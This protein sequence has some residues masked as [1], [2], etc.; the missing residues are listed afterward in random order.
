M[1]CDHELANEWARC[2]GKNASYIAILFI[3]L[4]SLSLLLLLHLGISR[5]I[6]IHVNTAEDICTVLEKS[7]D[8]ITGSCLEKLQKVIVY[9]YKNPK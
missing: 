8:S 2:S 4:L 3:Y 5:Q 1:P 6:S 9:K 7:I